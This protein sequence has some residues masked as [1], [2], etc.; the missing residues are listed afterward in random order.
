MHW[1]LRSV[2]RHQTARV[3][4]HLDHTHRSV[5]LRSDCTCRLDHTQERCT[6]LRLRS[7]PAPLL[8]RINNWRHFLNETRCAYNTQYS[9]EP[10]SR[11]L[12]RPTYGATHSKRTI[13]RN[14]NAPSARFSIPLRVRELSIT[15]F[16]QHTYCVAS[17]M[18]QTPHAERPSSCTVATVPAALAGNDIT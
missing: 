15:T 1:P 6:A 17:A 14:R 3:G 8:E 16:P 7:P 13:L 12:T 2:L 18:V 10:Q 5:A 9:P 4:S 11:T